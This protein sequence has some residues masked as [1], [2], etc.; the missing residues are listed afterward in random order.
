MR[1]LHAN[2]NT[3]THTDWVSN[4]K[5]LKEDDLERFTMIFYLQLIKL[6]DLIEVLNKASLTKRI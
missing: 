4:S 3:F 6:F 5:L 2:I 1:Y